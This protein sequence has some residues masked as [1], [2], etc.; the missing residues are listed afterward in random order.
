ML[1]AFSSPPEPPLGGSAF[2]KT[3]ATPAATAPIT[4]NPLEMM[5]EAA[6]LPV[7]DEVALE[8]VALA[9]DEPEAL[10]LELP[11]LAV[12]APKTPPWTVSGDLPCAFAAADLYASR[13]LPLDGGFTTKAI[14]PSQW[15]DT[16]Q[17]NHKG[18]V[19]LTWIRQISPS[20]G[21]PEYTPA[22]DERGT[23]G[24]PKLD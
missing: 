20:L 3:A 19:L 23:Q 14:P 9:V 4:I 6:A 17:Y 1:R 13:V 15:P 5:F 18:S 22:P 21:N 11:E 24:E 12:A 8:L 7:L 16:E 2:Y 10:V